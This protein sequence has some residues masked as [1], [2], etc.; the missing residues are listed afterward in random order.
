MLSQARKSCVNNSVI[1]YIF[2]FDPELLFFF[3]LLTRSNKQFRLH[4]YLSFGRG[5]IVMTELQNLGEKNR[6]KIQAFTC[7]DKLISELV[8]GYG[9][10]RDASEILK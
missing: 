4:E 1:I 10:A 8:V 3:I 6:T 5:L 7:F 9:E 2:K